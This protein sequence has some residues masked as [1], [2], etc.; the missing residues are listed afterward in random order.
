MAAL[1]AN[2]AATTTLRNEIPKTFVF[3][4]LPEMRESF[5][6]QRGAYDKP[7]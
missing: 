3:H 2:D 1:E 6:M 5:V 7:G 4:D